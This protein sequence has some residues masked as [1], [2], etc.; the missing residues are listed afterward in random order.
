MRIEQ[1]VED[2]PQ[3]ANDNWECSRC[4]G[5][6]ASTN[7]NSQILYVKFICV[8]E[9][10]HINVYICECVCVSDA[11][12]LSKYCGFIVVMFW[13]EIYFINRTL[14]VEFWAWHTVN[15]TE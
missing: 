2:V 8:S 1:I 5:C 9:F 11:V 4:Y 10:M 13:L 6:C 3:D 15:T 12:E 14:F 7:A